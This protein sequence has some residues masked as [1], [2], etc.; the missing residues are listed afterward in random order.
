MYYLNAQGAA[1]KGTTWI[2]AT[3]NELRYW[4]G[5]TAQSV[6]SVSAM[7]TALAGKSDTT[8]NHDAAYSAIA[9]NHDAAY[10]NVAGDTMTGTLNLPAST[11]A[12]GSAPL[13]I[14]Q[15][16]LMT[17]AETGA[18]EYDGTNLYFTD[19]GGV[20]RQL[21]VSGGAVTWA[22]IDKTVSSL[23]D[24]TTRSATD[25]NSG[26]LNDLRLSSNVPLKNASN[27]F[28]TGGQSIVNSGATQVPLM[29][30]GFAAQAANLLEVKDSG[31]TTL[32]SLQ[33]LGVPTVTTDLTTRDW[34]ATALAGKADTTHTHDADYVNVGGDTMT[35]ALALPSNGLAVGATQLV[36][37][38]G[39][40]GIGTSGPSSRLQ[41]NAA[42]GT[43]SKIS[44]SGDDI[45]HGATDDVPTNVFG[46]L[47]SISGSGAGGLR[48]TGLSESPSTA[49]GLTLQGAKG[50]G[51]SSDAAVIFHASELS[52]TGMNGALEPTELAFQ[53]KNQ[54]TELVTINGL[55]N[56]GIGTTSP[57]AALHLKAGT[58]TADTAPLKLT[59]GTN[60]TAAEAG[61]IEFDGT[62]LY[63]TT[64]TPTRRTIATTTTLGSY[65]AKSGDSMTGTLSVTK[66]I[67]GSALVVSAPGITS[68]AWAAVESTNPGR[69]RGVSMTRN[70]ANTGMGSL[71]HLDEINSAANNSVVYI[72]NNGIGEAIQIDN[73]GTGTSFRVDDQSGDTSPFLIDNAGNV[74][75]GTT[76]PTD[77]L[78][79]IGQVAVDDT[80]GGAR[81]CF[82]YTGTAM[83]FSNNCENGT[84]TWTAIG[85]GG[86][87]N[88]GNH[89]ATTALQMAGQTINGNSAAGGD[90]ILDSTSNAAKG[91]IVLQPSGGNVGIGVTPDNKLDILE[92][93]SS[94]EM[95]EFRNSTD[96]ATVKIG[97]LASNIGYIWAGGNDALVLGSDNS[98]KMRI[99]SNGDVGI[100]TT[101]P[102]YK[103]QVSPTSATAGS[104][105][106]FQ[107]QT[108]ATGATSVVIKGGAG[109]STTPLLDIQNSSGAS[110]F[111]VDTWTGAMFTNRIVSNASNTVPIDIIGMTGGNSGAS[112]TI[113]DIATRNVTNGSAAQVLYLN[114]NFQMA[115]G[116]SPLATLR[117]ASVFNQT[118][119]ANGISRGLYVNDTL[120]SAVD[121]R[122][123][124]MS[125]NSGFGIYQSGASAKN[126]FNGNIGIA[127]T[128]PTDQLSVIGQIAV[129][130][131]DGG[132]RGCFRYTGTSLEY[133]NNCESGTPTWTAL[134]TGG[135]SASGTAGH[136]QFSNGSGGFTSDTNQLFWD[137][138]NDYLG[139]GTETPG[140]ALHVR[141]DTFDGI[142]WFERTT[143]LTNIER[144]AI[145]LK[146]NSSNTIADG[147]GPSMY[148]KIDGSGIPEQHIGR[149]TMV[150]SGADNSGAMEFHT[151]N[152]G[153]ETVKM[154]ILPDGNVG[155][156]TPS[157]TEL[158]HLSK[159]QN[160]GTSILVQNTNAGALAKTGFGAT[161]DAGTFAT[162]ISSLANGWAGAA[163]VWNGANTPLFFGTNDNLRMTIL[164]SGNVGIGAA[165]PTD[166]LSVIG[167]VSVDDTDG[168]ARGCLRYS[169][170][171]LEFANNCESGTPT[172]TAIGAS[173]GVSG[174]TA[175]RI[176]YA[177][178][179]TTLADNGS[180]VWDNA[181]TRLA[182]GTGSPDA[183]RLH[184]NS[185]DTAVT[186]A[187]S[188]LFV[189]DSGSSNAFHTLLTAS[190]TG[191]GLAVTN[192]GKV[193]IGST[194]PST[195]MHLYSTSANASGQE[196]GLYI[197]A[198][199]ATGNQQSVLGLITKG[200]GTKQLGDAATKGWAIAGRGDA[201]TSATDRN[202]FFIFQANGTTWT[203]PFMID[204]ATGNLGAGTIVPTDKLSV[205]GQLAVDNTDGGARGCFRYTG[206][207]LEFAN[208]CESGTPT[209]AAIGA[210]GAGSSSGTAGHLQFSDGA[211]GFSSETNQLNWNTTSKQLTIGTVTAAPT[212]TGMHLEQSYPLYS[213]FDSDG[214]L[215]PTRPAWQFGAWGA[216]F[217]IRNTTDYSTYAWPFTI[218]QDGRT[219][220]GTATP[221]EILHV[222]KNQDARTLMKVLNTNTTMAS[223]AGIRLA[224]AAAGSQYSDIYQSYTVNTLF[225]ENGGAANSKI[226]FMTKPAAGGAA[227]RM[228][229]DGDGN[230]GIGTAAPGSPLD[231]RGATAGNVINVQSTSTSG[232][233]YAVYSR[234]TGAGAITNVGGYFGAS[235]ATNNTAIYIP[236]G[237][238]VDAASN[239]AIY[240]GSAAQTYFGGKVG[241]GV[242]NPSNDLDVNGNI[243][244]TNALMVGAGGS[245]MIVNSSGNVGVGTASPTAALHLKAGTAA[246]GTAPLKFTTGVNLG[247]PEVGAVE[248]DGTN[249]F[250]TNG[251]GR[252]TVATTAGAG[253]GWTD[254]GTD[255][256]LSTIT[257]KVGIG[258]ATPNKILD[259]R[260]ATASVDGIQYVDTT[261]GNYLTL[262]EYYGQ[263]ALTP[264][265][266]NTNAF[267]VGNGWSNGAGI[268]LKGLGINHGLSMWG[269]GYATGG[270]ISFLTWN[271]INNDGTQ[272]DRL[273]IKHTTGNVGIGTA[274]PNG[275]VHIKFASSGST[276]ND[277]I[278]IENDQNINP[279]T[280][281]NLANTNGHANWRIANAGNG[282]DQ[283]GIGPN[284]NNSLAI[285]TT[286]MTTIGGING[287]LSL[288]PLGVY[289][290]AAIGS[291]YYAATAAPANGLIVEG[292]VG[293]GT[294][295]PDS[296]L[297]IADDKTMTNAGGWIQNFTID[298]TLS[299]SDNGTNNAVMYG[300]V[301]DLTN[302][303]T[304]SDYAVVRG[305]SID[306]RTADD[307]GDQQYAAGS[308]IAMET[309]GNDI[310][311]GIVISDAWADVSTGG[312]QYGLKIDISDANLADSYGIYQVSSNKNSF[313]GNVGIGQTTP[314]A[315][316]H[317]KAGTATA[318]TAP[319]KLTS[320]TN[321]TTPEAG[322]IEFDG[323]KLYYTDNQGTPVRREIATVGG[324]GDNLGNHTATTNLVMG[325]NK[326]IGGTASGNDVTIEST[327]HATK[328]DVVLQPNGGGVAIG[329]T[330][331]SYMLD[332]TNASYAVGVAQFYSA[333]GTDGTSP[334]VKITNDDITNGQSDGLE[335]NAGNGNLDFPLLVS[336]RTGSAI[337]AVRG[338]GNVGIGTAAPTHRFHVT[339]DAAH[340][341][342]YNDDGLS[343]VR[344]ETG[345]VSDNIEFNKSG[346][347]FTAV[348]TDQSLGILGWNG[349]DGTGWISSARIEGQTDGTP[350]T[351]DMP[352]RLLFMTTPDGSAA[353]VERMRITSA[354]NVGIGTASPSSKL[355]IANS[356]WSTMTVEDSSAGASASGLA[357]TKN[358]YTASWSNDG[359]KLYVWDSQ[360]A[361][362]T[363][364]LE[365]NTGRLWNLGD[366]S[367]GD[368]ALFADKETG[369][370]G[371]GTLVPTD[372][373][374]VIGQL[375]VDNTDG[376]ARGCFRY[377]GTQMEFA[378]NCESGTPTWNAIGTGGAPSFPLLGSLGSAGA[379]TYSF[380]GDSNNGIY[381]PGADQVAIATNGSQRFLVNGDGTSTIMADGSNVPWDIARVT[382]NDVTNGEG[383]GFLVRAG[384]GSSDFP[385]KIQK[386][387]TTDLLTV[388]GDGNV[389]IG[390]ASPAET[391]HVSQSFPN[392]AVTTRVTNTDST[393]GSAARLWIETNGAAAGDPYV[394]FDNHVVDWSMG[395]DT[396]DS[397]KFK[398]SGSTVIGTNDYITVATGGNVGI[399]TTSPTNGKVDVQASDTNVL[400]SL[401]NTSS[402]AARQAGIKIADYTGGNGG[403]ATIEFLTS[404][405][406]L[407]STAAISNNDSLALLKFS[408]IYDN[409]WGVGYGANIQ[410]LA[411]G[412]FTST[413]NPAVMTFGTTPSGSTS[414]AERM[415]IAADGNVGI[416][417]ATPTSILHVVGAGAFQTMQSNSDTDWQKA[418]LSFHR[419]RG[420]ASS[421]T[422]VADL[423]SIG[424]LRFTAYSGGSYNLAA[425]ITSSVDGTPSGTNVPMN[426]NFVV[427]NGSG[428]TTPM[429]IRASGNVG[430]GTVSPGATLDV[431]G[432]IA[433]SNSTAPSLSSCGTSPTITGND[434]RG[435][436]TFGTGTVTSCT[437]TF[438][439]A[440]ASAP[441]CVT[442]ATG[443]V[444]IARPST[445]NTTTLTL[446]A[447]GNAA[448]ESFNYICLQ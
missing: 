195:L 389:G 424:A 211:G 41:V 334:M 119:T 378:N 80:D 207:Q 245:K 89:T 381:S 164:N 354:G 235:G 310:A 47:E 90:L 114:S 226:A 9:H 52:G 111:K 430:I 324:S 365:R 17:A 58:A 26:T 251:S 141:G 108:A 397:G 38:G 117:L 267:Q 45:A 380:T 59:A 283:F 194:A 437:I 214:S 372:K 356:G 51:S 22:S 147:F 303:V 95:A 325:T 142:A 188:V 157:P 1:A 379:P 42:T 54:N 121:Y 162:G 343:I 270:D 288:S 190:G 290:G 341:M 246:A 320:G 123:V 364:E 382:N 292:N 340:H 122:A 432:H 159:S 71:L 48:I 57:T 315:V 233:N 128:S 31:G 275:H 418:Q 205:I 124:E 239:Y 218:L 23:G 118:G 173:G 112:V 7:T 144:S 313:M 386:R 414:P 30:Q 43:S 447:A 346:T 421:P 323:T 127:T 167:Q 309:H 24:L 231:V 295:T 312:T 192:A 336:P 301:I 13:K 423:D 355:H 182:V 34:V 33:N 289:G 129:D 184:L 196:Q 172:W 110:V 306:V 229:I 307:S 86:A 183:I 329:K 427:N 258:I 77:N 446:T 242:L 216:E 68:N 98:E 249:L 230:V 348:A 403:Q 209:W 152:S 342:K 201:F 20:R 203:S 408:G 154:R 101:N 187:T 53:F 409:A 316:L 319:L 377:T 115:S 206:T 210:A 367:I 331:P 360:A 65:V 6:A 404:R 243:Q 287:P 178:S 63:F 407:S 72:R 25:L 285:T 431:N 300:Q 165:V 296:R 347:G 46:M 130:N 294:T 3:T 227:E 49:A 274:A 428:A 396:S 198:Q 126:Y 87:D 419:S 221:A 132:A 297:E 97:S 444:N 131:I 140:R 425:Q 244:T 88:L 28:S 256:V 402:T 75:I 369:T 136:L 252:Q 328:G 326:I 435:K 228:R 370:V 284:G 282:N 411:A 177:S 4:D 55:G 238:P 236:S 19:S 445:V 337:F 135:G 125:N 330:G 392:D 70:D 241:I 268:E 93:T 406:T 234:A 29:L 254:S 265:S 443:S 433:A 18:I 81:G 286:G 338:D 155:I 299:G 60:L 436:I 422:D 137:S 416:G 27:V 180:F 311:E 133:A 276:A 66:S 202:D 429:I 317:L 321:L 219:G 176:P 322:A 291:S 384:N 215:G 302:T 181:N 250:F 83:E 92:T 261:T 161:S 385:L 390:T 281:I 103:F 349:H 2:N 332:V 442:V 220:I 280:S 417:T 375:A 339:T 440:Y 96:T 69:G 394:R 15:G 383:H 271:G 94:I 304:G 106:L 255:V 150:R 335:I 264:N 413:S 298:S 100:G 257:D 361:T 14:A 398:I 37:S 279:V 260:G 259:V 32:Y 305:Q 388:R 248:F 156:G 237:S 368:G 74:G 193:G 253:G 374:S 21:G 44:L 269:G 366:A 175:G 16:S 10:V 148:F 426:L 412:N 151:A 224:T 116:S 105:A 76:G 120:T 232:A 240:S 197:D 353:S 185:G 217:R 441:Y 225:I 327:T 113:S 50:A 434:T 314:T 149:I 358:G 204:S 84:P 208:N 410:V 401:I 400:L 109:Q 153:A 91:E 308:L 102:T 179:G 191:V 166:K 212:Q 277:G 56:V 99:L 351:N 359:V 158:L 262:G 8:H 395:T 357:L 85:S 345:N 5:A 266:N 139:I 67:D 387:D 134:S 333:N 199:G 213:S 169:G 439:T 36:V 273:T 143:A 350:G 223:E 222:E 163:Y 376:G 12:A 373:L 170:T 186:G 146:A 61:A 104:T 399:G 415:R 344:V 391:L 73:V 247:T 263:L 160:A 272:L 363:F 78:S 35:G 362:E 174:L 438:A 420:T 189:E 39:N 171:Q 79:V 448:G 82:R 293:F 62:N 168:G 138:T 352:G 40:V 107:D 64:S 371:I 393:A 318:N 145:S 11:A 278:F 200:D 405:G